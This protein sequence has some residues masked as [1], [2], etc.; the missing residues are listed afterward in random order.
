VGTV[1]GTVLGVVWKVVCDVVWAAVGG[2][3]L[4]GTC[5]TRSEGIRS[6]VRTAI[7]T[8]TSMATRNVI[9]RVTGEVSQSAIREGTCGKILGATCTAI[10]LVILRAPVTVQRQCW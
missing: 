7:P 1:P 9:G 5:G 10:P 3:I 2:V 6:P 8:V 4:T